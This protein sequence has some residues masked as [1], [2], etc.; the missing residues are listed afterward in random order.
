M[1]NKEMMY[2]CEPLSDMLKKNHGKRLH[3]PLKKAQ[4]LQK[5]RHVKIL[6]PISDIKSTKVYETC[7]KN[8]IGL[9]TG[10]FSGLSIPVMIPF[11]PD[12]QI[13]KAYNEAMENRVKDWVAFIDH[14]VFLVN[15]LWHQICVN[16][17]AQVGDKAGWITC[18][19]NR[20]GCKF[21]KAPIF[22]KYAMLRKSDD[23]RF[24]REY[25]KALY[26]RNR[27]QIKDTT[28][29]KGGR[30]SGMFILT[31]RKAWKLAGGF[32]EN[33]GFFNVDC[34]YYTAIQNAGLRTYVMQDMY[35]YHG[36]FREVLKPFFNEE[37]KGAK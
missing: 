7:C 24:H 21:Q 32:V 27:G 36:Y 35:V 8:N 14:D 11:M 15:P 4:G 26:N 1:S 30:F 13:G 28:N 10:E 3:L 16:A 19:T 5:Q 2:V 6:H 31:N 33:A 25:G 9:H 22:G 29:M 23:I 20:I 12:K 37:E 18:L 34:K 17:I